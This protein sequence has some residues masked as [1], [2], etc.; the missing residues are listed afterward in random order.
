V[1]QTSLL[2]NVL[3]ARLGRYPWW[4]TLWSFPSEDQASAL[5]LLDRLGIGSLAPRLAGEVSGGEQQR[6]A[7]A[8]ALFSESPLLLADEP[9]ANLD[10]GHAARVLGM[11]RSHAHEHG[12]AVVCV[13]HHPE[14]AQG[15]ADAVLTIGEEWPFG[16]NYKSLPEA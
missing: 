4:K 6:T 16:W 11:L 14:Q 12:A 8:R 3:M 10:E 15:F 7:V 13:L 2:G 9:V 5:S 1:Y